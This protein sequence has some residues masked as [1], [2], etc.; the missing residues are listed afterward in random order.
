MPEST[1]SGRSIVQVTRSV[2][3]AIRHCVHSQRTAPARRCALLAPFVNE[4]S[5][6]A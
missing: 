3:I 4:R 5:H 6:L 2:L 1:Q